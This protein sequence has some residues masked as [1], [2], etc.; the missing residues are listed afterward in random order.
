[1]VSSVTSRELL[2]VYLVVALLACRTTKSEV[3]TVPA[4][5][6]P[7]PSSKPIRSW[8]DVPP[9]ELLSLIVQNFDPKTKTVPAA[10]APPG[11]KVPPGAEP[12]RGVLSSSGQWQRA[13]EVDR[14][15]GDRAP[16][17]LDL[18]TVTS[19]R[20]TFAWVKTG[21]H[22]GFCM[23]G[24]GF[25]AAIERSDDS[26]RVVG[27]LP[28]ELTCAEK[29]S[30]FER[31]DLGAVQGVLVKEADGSEHGSRD[32]FHIL[33][34]GP[35]GL[36]AAG[37]FLGS[38]ED[39]QPWEGQVTRFESTHA[40]EGGRLV[41]REKKTEQTCATAETCKVTRT[42]QSEKGFRLQDGKLVEAK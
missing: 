20:L 27:S 5:S 16:V 1:M 6:A 40:V 21:T 42:S 18:R 33:V 26:L 12:S 23:P 13:G 38:G 7:A 34:L 25:V 9:E 11:T 3:V 8:D 14:P 37:R 10:K 39:G 31:L 35:R 19:D 2:A 28:F 41:V 29:P 17:S 22:N 15:V 32:F 36:E 24:I 30:A 4:A